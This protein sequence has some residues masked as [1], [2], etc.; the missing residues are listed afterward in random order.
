MCGIAGFVD[1]GTRTSAENG[2]SLARRMADA[3]R[4]RGPDD[5]GVWSD[6][7]AGAFLAHRRLSILDLSPAGH[8]PMSS[9]SGRYILVFNGEIYNH[10]DIRKELD[11][12]A[13][14][15]WRGH[16][17]TEVVLAA[18]DQWG[19]RG[20]L[21]RFVGM[22]AIALWDRRESELTLARDRAGEK[23]I[24]WGRFG[25]I[26]L[27]GSELKALRA[28]PGFKAE[29]DREALALF[30]RH[31]CVPAPHCIY[32]G[33]RKVQ[34]G[35]LIRL[36]SRGSPAV[37]TYWS[38]RGHA[39][40]GLVRRWEGDEAGA[41]T[42]LERLIGQSV[43]MQLVADVP[44]GAFLS[45]GID[46]SLVV[47][48]AQSRSSRPIRTFSIGFAEEQYDE[49]RF[50][51]A[52]A[53]HLGTDHTEMYVSPAQAMEVI[54]SLAGIYDEPFADPSQIPTFL[55]AQLA[56]RHVTVSISGDGGDEL[57]AGYNRHTQA[58]RLQHLA[59]SLPRAV[60]RALAAGLFSVSPSGWDR[61]FGPISATMPGRLRHANIG[62]KLHRVARLMRAGSV[63]LYRDLTSHW[64]EEAV[65]IGAGVPD[66]ERDFA[67]GNRP[68]FPG[69][70]ETAAWLDFVGYL[71]DDILVKVDRAS[72]AVSLESRVPLLDHR[73]IEFAWRLP[74][75]MKLREGGG[76]WLLRQVLYRYVP[77]KLLDRP[78]MGFS[79][80]L[81]AWLRGPLRSWAEALLDEKRL[82]REGYFNPRPIREKW[83]EH[84]S[85]RRNWQ[86]WL[87]DVLMFQAWSERNG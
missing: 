5:A 29:V 80:P 32:R 75:E 82:S 10:G 45:G 11:G 74:M 72:M 18:I 57:F 64:T 55:V 61:L 27:F 52:V 76:K 43:A 40:A 53:G 47:A 22:F 25:D 41:A 50:A 85:G 12:L 73:V 24:F 23:P 39:D 60:R 13:S 35:T 37:E 58:E 51:R 42:E 62:D 87:W 65:V 30:L 84:L 7:G 6:A 8:Q 44:V 2:E 20:A 34:P 1:L 56:R 3:L 83:S 71:P 66:S 17:D 36:R 81:H 26:V 28:H 19:M 79:I 48:L 70:A 67:D 49:A 59:S 14:R 31:S 68:A 15:S 69:F 38:A 54:P 4:H 33:V 16:S 9:V 46:S 86:Y 78:K 63:D 21:D 77:R